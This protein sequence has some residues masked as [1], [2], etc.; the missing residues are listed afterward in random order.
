ME[1]TESFKLGWIV[2]TDGFLEFLDRFG[3]IQIKKKIRY[4]QVPYGLCLAACRACTEDA[5][6]FK[7]H[8][9]EARTQEELTIVLGFQ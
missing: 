2:P 9:G 1:G 6:A 7:E 4:W 3:I 5:T 8:V